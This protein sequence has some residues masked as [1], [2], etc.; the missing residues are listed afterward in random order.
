MDERTPVARDDKG[1]F[2]KGVSGNPLGRPQGRK[3]EIVRLKQ[4]LEIAIR[5]HVKAESV[6]DIINK[7]V[8]KARNG[9]VAAAKLILDKVLSNAREVEDTPGGEGGYKIVIENATFA[10]QGKENPQPAQQPAV[11]AEYTEVK[12]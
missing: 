10:V 3:N 7:M 8:N 6:K 1:R 5:Q 4:D 2:P 11:D 9:D 12:Q